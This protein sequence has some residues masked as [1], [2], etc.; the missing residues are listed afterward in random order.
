ML[1]IIFAVFAYLLGSV[2]TAILVCQFLKLPDPRTGG[3]KNPGATNVLRMA[4]RNPAILVLV[5]DMFKGFIVV[6]LA[7]IFGVSGFA[8]ALVALAAALGHIFPVFYGFQG[9]KGVATALGGIL[10]LSFPVGIVCLVAWA[11]SL[12]ITRYASL[13]SLIAVS[14]APVL[15]LF[16]NLSYFIPVLVLA[17]IVAWRH[18]ENIARL[19]VGTENKM[20]FGNPPKAPETKE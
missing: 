6:L 4:G 2:N 8:L 17:A 11:V 20:S 10:G 16:V 15:L 19:R 1:A 7:A 13:S 9:G 5:A 12:F 14:M 18:M 3:S